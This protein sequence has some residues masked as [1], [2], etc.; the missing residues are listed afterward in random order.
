MLVDAGSVALLAFPTTDSACSIS[1]LKAVDESASTS[2]P[3][4]APSPRRVFFSHCQAGSKNGDVPCSSSPPSS[5]HAIPINAPCAQPCASDYATDT[6]RLTSP[7]TA[8]TALPAESSRA[9]VRRALSLIPEQ[10]CSGQS[11]GR[12]TIPA[13]PPRSAS[14][15]FSF[16]SFLSRRRSKRATTAADGVPSPAQGSSPRSASSTL[17]ST[18]RSSP[19]VSP[20]TSISRRSRLLR[21]KRT[22]S[23]LRAPKL[24]GATSRFIEDLPEWRPY[25]RSPTSPRS[26]RHWRRRAG[27]L[28]RVVRSLRRGRR[29]SHSGVD[30]S[31]SSEIAAGGTEKVESARSPSGAAA[32]GWWKWGRRS[33][34]GAR[35]NQAGDASG[36]SHWT[37]RRRGSRSSGPPSHSLPRCHQADPSR[38]RRLEKRL[39]QLRLR[40]GRLVQLHRSSAAV[41]TVQPQQEAPGASR[42]L[43]PVQVGPSRR[44]SK[45]KKRPPLSR[46]LRH[47]A[48]SVSTTE[49]T[50]TLSS[51]GGSY[52]EWRTSMRESVHADVS[53]RASWRS[54]RSGRDTLAGADALR[55]RTRPGARETSS[56]SS[57]H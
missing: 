31:E 42:E 7:A 4:I 22:L 50:A 53:R 14:S 28:E 46:T 16:T 55:A 48:A 6:T 33:K 29:G 27:S 3:D 41:S 45:L 36:R 17:P 23:G 43:T 10:S 12:G 32:A 8:D 44:P 35:V 47:S 19:A 25:T 34:E 26:S 37:I 2:A 24:A 30:S 40:V 5:I 52:A 51:R 15:R 56:R 38:G 20:R 18:H 11:A 49:M 21:R 13:T 39:R 9:P 1:S 54:A 57:R